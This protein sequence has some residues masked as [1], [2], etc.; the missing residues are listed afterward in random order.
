[1]LSMEKKYISEYCYSQHLFQ[2]NSL[3]GFRKDPDSSHPPLLLLQ[4][5]PSR[6]SLAAATNH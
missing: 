6:F 4:I 5:S 3:Y 1:M 2:I